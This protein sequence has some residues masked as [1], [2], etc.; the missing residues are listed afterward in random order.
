LW[1]RQKGWE[2]EEGTVMLSAAQP[3][4]TQR[5]RL[6]AAAQGDTGKPLDTQRERPFAVAQGDAGKHLDTQRE[7]PFAVAQGDT[8]SEWGDTVK[9]LRVVPIG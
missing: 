7:R 8:G 3:L 5:A 1:E 9:H 2:Q 6:F 4:D